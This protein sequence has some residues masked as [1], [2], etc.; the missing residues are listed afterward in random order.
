MS[1]LSLIN[2]ERKEPISIG[3]INNF[4]P[5][6][7]VYIYDMIKHVDDINVLFI[8]FYL[9]FSLKLLLPPP[10]YSTHELQKY[11]WKSTWSS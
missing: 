4:L 8:K 1:L 2:K 10:Y 9:F 6:V 5:S 11:K 7:P 3:E